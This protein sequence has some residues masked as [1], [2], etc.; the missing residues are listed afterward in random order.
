MFLAF[1]Q[2][3]LKKLKTI[4][5]NKPILGSDCT[6]FKLQ[7]KPSYNNLQFCEIRQKRFLMFCMGYIVV[8]SLALACSYSYLLNLTFLLIGQKT[9]K[10]G[11]EP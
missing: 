10:R 3:T 1:I 5:N 8:G 9:N 4:L 6:S 2:H 7:Y 11:F